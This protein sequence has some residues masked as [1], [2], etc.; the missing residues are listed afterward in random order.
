[1]RDPELSRLFAFNQSV[2]TVRGNRHRVDLVWREG[3]LLIEVDGEDH[4]NNDIKY[5]ADRVRDY[6]LNLSGYFVL[7]LTSRQI[8]ADTEMSIDRIRDCVKYQR[9]NWI[10]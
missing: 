5:E 3:K 6:E 10:T 2:E 8:L 7:R 4:F 1:M 9:A